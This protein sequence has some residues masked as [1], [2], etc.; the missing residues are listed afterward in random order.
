MARYMYPPNIEGKHPTFMM[1]SSYKYAK[2]VPT[3]LLNTYFLPIPTELTDTINAQY[4][5]DFEGYSDKLVQ[6][7]KDLLG[8]G[9]KELGKLTGATVNKNTAPIFQEMEHR[10]FSFNWELKAKTKKDADTMINLLKAIREDSKAEKKE[11]SGT[12]ILLKFPPVWKLK[13]S[14]GDKIIKFSREGYVLDE[15]SV[16]F[17]EGKWIQFHDGNP[18]S[19]MLNMNFIE[20]DRP[21]RG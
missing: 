10:R 13:I 18:V 11:A 2:T 16:S 1:I 21:V 9:G 3:E 15:I 20:R 17:N 6:K 12:G 5:V 4:E 7:G 8:S 14:S 19:A